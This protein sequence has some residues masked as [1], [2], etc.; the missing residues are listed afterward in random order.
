MN[1]G[2]VLGLLGC[3]RESDLGRGREVS[4]NLPPCRIVG[5]AA[6]MTLINYDQIKKAGREFPEELLP[7]LLSCDGLVESQIYLVG[8]VNAALFVQ[9]CWEF[10]LGAILTLDGFRARAELGHC[11]AEGPKIINHR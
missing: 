1:I 5:G 8:C 10:D 3:G 11:R 2:N 7:F 6:A 4:K 9:R